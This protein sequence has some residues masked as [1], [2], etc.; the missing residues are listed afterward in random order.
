MA[1]KIGYVQSPE[2]TRGSR[3]IGLGCRRR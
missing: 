3:E 2:R 1:R